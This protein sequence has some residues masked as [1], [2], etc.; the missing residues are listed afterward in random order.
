MRKERL[1]LTRRRETVQVCWTRHPA[2][3]LSFTSLLA[4]YIRVFQFPCRVT[5]SVPEIACHSGFDES[6]LGFLKIHHKRDSRKKEYKV[7]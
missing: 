1:S 7:K 6:F 2:T 5:N 3:N 4:R